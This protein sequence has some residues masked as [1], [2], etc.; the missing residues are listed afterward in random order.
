MVDT[1]K[2]IEAS[3]MPIYILVG[4]GILNFILGLIGVGILGAILGLVSLAVSIWAGYNAVKAFKLDLMGAGLV[5][6][7]VSVVA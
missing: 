2:I 6:V 4:L 7:V 1:G 5:G 3:K